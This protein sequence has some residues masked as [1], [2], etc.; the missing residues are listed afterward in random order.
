MDVTVVDA[1]LPLHSRAPMRRT[2]SP[3]DFFAAGSDD[4]TKLLEQKRG[5]TWRDYDGSESSRSVDVDQESSSSTHT[6]EDESDAEKYIHFQT[7]PRIAYQRRASSSSSSS[8]AR[9]PD[10]PHSLSTESAKSSKSAASRSAPQETLE[11][12]A[13]RL[14][15]FAKVVKH[16]TFFDREDYQ[17]VHEA[18]KKAEQERDEFVK[19]LGDREKLARILAERERVIEQAVLEGT[20]VP[21]RDEEL[22]RTLVRKQAMLMQMLQ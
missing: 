10:S 18:A 9:P 6:K 3:D 22:F 7:S 20:L 17:I 2:F 16:N 14:A 13:Q 21:T 12:R 11:Q 8:S 1:N 5:D 15:A 4:D 19:R